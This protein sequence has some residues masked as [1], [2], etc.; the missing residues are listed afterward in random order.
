MVL[1]KD[2]EVSLCYHEPERWCAT[3]HD[4]QLGVVAHGPVGHTAA[5]AVTA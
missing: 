2:G 3:I 4:H 5:S 1:S